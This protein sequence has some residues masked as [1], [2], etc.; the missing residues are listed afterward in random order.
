MQC[1]ER[2]GWLDLIY[3]FSSLACT[4][5]PANL[6]VSV[7]NMRRRGGDDLHGI[8]VVDPKNMTKT[9]EDLLR[10]LETICSL[11]QL[12]DKPEL[13]ARGHGIEGWTMVVTV[14]EYVLGEGQNSR[15]GAAGETALHGAI[16]ALRSALNS[17]KHAAAIVSDG[18]MCDREID[19]IPDNASNSHI[20]PSRPRF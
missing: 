19:Q 17:P 13:K 4:R 6:K 7:A 16:E 12:G 15:R 14:G 20:E 18:T 1:L 5:Y 3:S 9:E 10:Q 11:H 2:E 8:R